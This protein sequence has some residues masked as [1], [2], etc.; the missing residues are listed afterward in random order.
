MMLTSKEIKRRE[1]LVD[2]KFGWLSIWKAVH[3]S[4]GSTAPLV[5]YIYIYILKRYVHTV[6]CS[7]ALWNRITTVECWCCPL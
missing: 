1:A 7:V 4:E 5:S 3:A 2:P 6:I